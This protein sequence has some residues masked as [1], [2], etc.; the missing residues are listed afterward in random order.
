MLSLKKT[1]SFKI[2]DVMCTRVFVGLFHVGQCLGLGPG[3]GFRIL[4]VP[5]TPVLIL[6]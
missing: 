1:R 2:L 6:V 4:W 5:I 3:F